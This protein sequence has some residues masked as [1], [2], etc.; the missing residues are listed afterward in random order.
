MPVANVIPAVP[1]P[2]PVVPMSPSEE[3]INSFKAMDADMSGH[4]DFMEIYNAAKAL[5][6]ELSMEELN[7]LIENADTDK[8]EKI[9]MAEFAALFKKNPSD[10]LVSIGMEVAKTNEKYVYICILTC[11]HAYICILTCIHA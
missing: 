3:V 2:A 1:V 11:K 9:S 8:D 7:H 4:L 6:K 10:L 5:G